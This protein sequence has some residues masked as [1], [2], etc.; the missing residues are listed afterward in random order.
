MVIFP[1]VEKTLVGYFKTAFTTAGETVRVG[2]RKSPPDKPRPPKELVINVSY[3]SEQ[4]F[5]MK[6]AI[7]TLEV[8]ADTYEDANAI[9]LL[10]ESLVRGCVGSEIKRAEVLAGPIRTREEG[11]QE[12][13]YLD[14]SLTIKG[15][16]P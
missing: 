14:V 6:D 13:R 15:T 11:P 2:T 1:D 7:V 16:N 12:K 9:A 8:Y 10:T 4:D 5:V 3:Q